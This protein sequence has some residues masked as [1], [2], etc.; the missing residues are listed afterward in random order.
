MNLK[1]WTLT[2]IIFTILCILQIRCLDNKTI[3]IVHIKDSDFSKT[4]QQIKEWRIIGPFLIDTTQISKFNSGLDRDHLINFNLKENFVTAHQFAILRRRHAL[5]KKILPGIFV[6]KLFFVKDDHID[7]RKVLKVDEPANSYIGCEIESLVERDIVFLIG[8]DDGIKIWFNNELLETINVARKIHRYQNFVVAHARKG[9]NFLL[10]KANNY[11]SD[12]R[13]LFDISSIESAKDLIIKNGYSRSNFLSN[14]I[15]CNGS[16]SLKICLKLFKSISPAQIKISG[17]MNDFSDERT[18]DFKDGTS[19]IDIKNLSSGLYYCQVIVE[20]DTFRQGFLV[21]NEHELLTKFEA[22]AYKFLPNNNQ[23][24][25]NLNILLLRYKHLMDPQSIKLLKYQDMRIWKRKVLYIALELDNLLTDL[26]HGKES[27][28]N[29]PGTHLRTFKSRIDDQV[30]SYLIHAPDKLHKDSLNALLINIPFRVVNQ[31]PFYKNIII[32]DI[33][34]IEQYSN[35]ADLYN[36]LMLWPSLRGN[37]EGSEI[38]VADLFESINA[39]SKNY[40]IDYNRIYLMGTCQGATRALLIAEKYPSIFAAFGLV[41]PITYYP[42]NIS[43]FN[44]LESVSNLK[45]ISLYLAHSSDDKFISIDHSDKLF[46]KVKKEQI[47][48]AYKRIRGY[49]HLC[50]PNYIQ[51]EMVHF[52]NNHIKSTLPNEIVFSTRSLKYGEAYWIKLKQIEYGKLAHLTAHIENNNF[53]IDEVKNVDRFDIFLNQ[54]KIEKSKHI[55]VIKDGAIYYN[56]IPP[57]TIISINLSLNTGFCDAVQIAKNEFIEGPISHVFANKFIVVRGTLLD[58]TT[59]QTQ[60]DLFKEAWQKCF[61]GQCCVK[62]DKEITLSDI[63]NSNFILLGNQNTNAFI[64][65]IIDKLPLQILDDRIIVDKKEY[66]GDDL[67]I[68]FIYPNPL[69]QNKYIVIIGRNDNSSF[70]INHNIFFNTNYDFGIFKCKGNRRP[71]MLAHG[72]FNKFWKV[73]N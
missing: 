29:V 45:N 73:D 32:S 25:S 7:F 68:Q 52:L 59:N 46:K 69:N 38:E 56:M 61:L 34:A 24:Q 39:C 4:I 44:I 1:K 15:L 36:C 21:G 22:R 9:K 6:N 31:L 67:G 10:I 48:V 42:M 3:P 57:D 63:K 5:D 49:S 41:S 16:D 13:L 64:K 71:F 35:I 47:S 58:S 14:T 65:Q 12:W 50:Y 2:I 27:F 19:V 20:N 17:S 60:V 28:K 43:P 23:V 51:T 40:R 30:Q 62:T 72:I 18:V 70:D 11:K 55:K 26:E 53:I 8:S 54:T 37:S 66:K 33:D